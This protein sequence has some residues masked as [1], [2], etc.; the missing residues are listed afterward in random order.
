MNRSTPSSVA[1]KFILHWG[2]MGTRWGI[3]R[4]VAQIHAL[5]FLSPRRRPARSFRV[6]ERRFRDVPGHYP[7]AKKARN[8]SDPPASTGM[9]YRSRQSEIS[10][11]LYQETIDRSV[12]I[13]RVGRNRL[14]AAGKTPDRG[15]AQTGQNG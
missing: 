15:L 5:L 13:F 1:Q 6:D 10:R 2:E 14:P 7:R 12:A 8:R 11:S 4:T 9:H 3:N